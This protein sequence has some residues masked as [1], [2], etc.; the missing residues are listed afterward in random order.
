MRIARILW[1]HAAVEVAR[2]T[3]FR[4]AIVIWM[5]T[6]VGGPLIL[7]MVWLRVADSGAHLAYD[8]SQLVSYF[9]LTMWS[10]MLMSV[11]IGSFVSDEIRLGM[12]SNRLLRPESP[13]NGY[14]ANNLGEKIVKIPVLAVLVGL[15]A[16]GFRANLHVPG[17]PAAWLVAVVAVVP[18]AIINFMF[19]VVVGSTA[20]Y[21]SNVNGLLAVRWLAGG[22]LAGY[23]APLA[24]FP[25]GV[26]H[27]LEW[28]PFRYTVSFPVEIVTTP[29]PATQI[30]RGLAVAVAYCVVLWIAYRVIWRLGLREYAASGI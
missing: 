8:R 2:F 16:F 20:F 29:L 15:I 21:F 23:V 7:L 4:G 11:W 12:L 14:I 5:L 1:L 3:E 13:L 17:P 25:D 18:G 26:R 6:L 9:L 27:V 19:D 24:L 10:G 30:V 28:L 22:L